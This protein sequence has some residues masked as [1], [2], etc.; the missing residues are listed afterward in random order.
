M[1]L[2]RVG[3]IRT[4]LKYGAAVLQNSSQ[5]SQ[6]ELNHCFRWLET[7]RSENQFRTD[8]SLIIMA[9]G[10]IILSFLPFITT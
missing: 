1:V 3:K 2:T 6:N 7:F 5:I 8:L 9:Q 10:K 4:P